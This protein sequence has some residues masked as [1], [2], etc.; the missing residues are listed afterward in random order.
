M[1]L[2]KINTTLYDLE[3][4]SSGKTVEYRPFLV[5]EE[6]ILLLALEG[7]E[8]KEM[9]RAIKQI[10]TQCVLTEGFDVNKTCNGGS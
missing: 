9:S 7:G 3:L 4:P 2:P 5:R 6:K 1:A 10:I 8:E